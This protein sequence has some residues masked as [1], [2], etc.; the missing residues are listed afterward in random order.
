MGR[1]GFKPIQSGPE[2]KSLSSIKKSFQN[3]SPSLQSKRPP[4]CLKQLT[5]Q[6]GLNQRSSDLTQSFL[7]T[8]KRDARCNMTRLDFGNEILMIEKRESGRRV[9]YPDRLEK[10][11]KKNKERE[12]ERERE[13][14]TKST[15][16]AYIIRSPISN[17]VRRNRPKNFSKYLSI[18]MCRLLPKPI[19]LNRNRI[20][21]K[22]IFIV[23][24]FVWIRT[25]RR[26]H[27]IVKMQVAIRHLRFN[28]AEML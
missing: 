2:T 18:L 16:T 24:C 26:F 10:H 7:D 11:K 21:D 15:S 5:Y 22:T 27:E 12:R 13:R 14:R 25:R 9:R 23:R 1:V 6:R 4:P 20:S 8:L 17:N 28:E 3:I 19:R